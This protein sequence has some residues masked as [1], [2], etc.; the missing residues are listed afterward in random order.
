MPELTQ[1]GPNQLDVLPLPEAR[2]AERLRDGHQR[3]SVLRPLE[4]EEAPEIGRVERVELDSD[5]ATAPAHDGHG[6]SLGAEAVRRF[7]RNLFLFWV[8]RILRATRQDVEQRF[9]AGRRDA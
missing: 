8:D 2:P 1:S 3:V 5:S 7:S 4:L 9:A 6:S